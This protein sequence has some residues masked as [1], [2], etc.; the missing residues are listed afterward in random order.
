MTLGIDSAAE[1]QSHADRRPGQA[2]HRRSREPISL[3]ASLSYER[4]RARLPEIALIVLATL[5]NSFFVLRDHSTPEWD[6]SNYLDTALH[7]RNAVPVGFHAFFH[8]VLTTSPAKA[9]LYPLLIVPFFALFDNSVRSALALN[10]CLWPVL[11]VSVGAIAGDLF[12]DRRARLLAIVF[13]ATMPLMVGLSHEVLQDFLLVTISTLTVALVIKSRLFSRPFVT[14]LV[15]LSV[16]LGMLTKVTFP[17]FV[18][19]PFAVVIASAVRRVVQSIRAKSW[20]QTVTL[21]R[22]LGLGVMVL[23]AVVIAALWYVPNYHATVDYIRSTTGGPLSLGA[24]PSNPLTVSAIGSFTIGMLTE[25]FSWVLTL[26]ALIG[27][28]GGLPRLR[29]WYERKA[30]LWNKGFAPALLVSWALLPYLSVALGHNQDVR[31]M[32]PAMPAGAIIVAGLLTAITVS[33]LRRASIAVVTVA[34]IFETVAI[35]VPFD[36]GFLPSEI[37]VSTGFGLAAIP[38]HGQAMGYEMPPGPGY[39]TQIIAA[40]ENQ[41]RTPFGKVRPETIG[42]LESDPVVNGN[43]LGWI[44][45]QR[46]D[47]FTIAN[48]SSS[49]SQ[50]AGL[51]RSL[52]DFDYLLYVRQPPLP[53][54]SSE[55]RLVLVNE[56][57]AAD[58]L[59]SKDL[60]HFHLRG[61]LPIGGGQNVEIFQ[62]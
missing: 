52:S 54:N 12:H 31:L 58:Y 4:I 9:P 3:P 60:G 56:S 7:L 38:L 19:G 25:H 29:L 8:A 42:V 28:I 18:L 57:F 35:A 23:L 21:P 30:S 22:I 41:S 11:L 27:V 32:A 13:T 40:I 10:V 46:G 15:G 36:A 5:G 62:P 33:A 39:G 47:Q 61:A 6:Q 1:V 49:S 43:T 34:A 2:R 37:S 45:D 53:A 17:V 20:R 26:G 50:H 14:A 16:G 59:T 55:N 48:V 51:V 44:A 24:G